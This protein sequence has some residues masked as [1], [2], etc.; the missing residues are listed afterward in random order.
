VARYSRD[1][2]GER[3]TC[4]VGIKLTPTEKLEFEAAAQALDVSLSTYLR[5]LCANRTPGIGAAS[6]RN[7]EAKAIMRE[8][9][10][11]GNNINQL[12]KHANTVDEMPSQAALLTAIDRLKEAMA[13]ILEL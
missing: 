11:I 10:A 2:I 6:R 1:Y 9:S 8:L 13:H 7:P 3:R 12:A 5:D 4:S